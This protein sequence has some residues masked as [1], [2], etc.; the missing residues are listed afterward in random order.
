MPEAE[1]TLPSLDDL[2]VF[3]L[4]RSARNGLIR[5]EHDGIKYFFRVLKEDSLDWATES[6]KTLVDNID[7]SSDVDRSLGLVLVNSGLFMSLEVNRGLGSEYRTDPS[8][9]W[10]L[11]TVYQHPTC[12]DRVCFEEIARRYHEFVNR[13]RR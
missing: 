2:M 10:R 9:E 12:K 8:K 5:V 6:V 4:I 3:M 11:K 7:I 13:S 1:A